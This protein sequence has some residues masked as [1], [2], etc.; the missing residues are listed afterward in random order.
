MARKKGKKKKGSLA[1]SR[2]RRR[3]R[4]DGLSK[5]IKLGKARASGFGKNIIKGGLDIPL[6]R[7]R[8]GSHIIDIIPYVVGKKDPDLDKGEE[9]YTYEYFVHTNVGPNNAWFLCPAQTYGEACPVCEHR[10]K[11]REKGSKKAVWKPL[12]PKRRNLYNIISYDRGEERKGV[13]VWDVPWFYS[14]K[15]LMAIA[16]KL[17]RKGRE[18]ETNFAHPKK[19]KSVQ[20]TI[21]P[22]KSKDDYASYDGWS[23]DDR[24][25]KLKN[26][27]LDE[28]H[29]LDQIIYIAPY[30]EIK[31]AYWKGGSRTEDGEEKNEEYQELIDE[32][33][34]LEDMDE[35]EEFIDENDLEVKIKKSDDEDDVKEKITEALEEQYSY[36]DDD[37]DDDDDDAD[38]DSD[39]VDPD[40]DDDED[41]EDEKLVKKINKM[42]E[43]K[44]LRYID[45]EDVDVDPDDA[46]DL[47]ELREMVI[48][49]LELDD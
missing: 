21:T 28:A 14:E 39:D 19:G 46:E 45:K 20:F 6:W 9:N 16:V 44:L 10:D 35:L 26:S 47:E 49:E 13:Q 36:E 2:E 8:D 29:T 40:D 22:A 33:E 30:D 43:K 27:T 1:R 23:F 41:D 48:E 24:D 15:H 17:D 31:E 37:D 32:L 38:D 25:Y 4:G 5:R 12:F 34:D 18:R 3:V 42:S 7:P 11:L